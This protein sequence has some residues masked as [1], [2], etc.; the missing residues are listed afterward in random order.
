LYPLS[1]KNPKEKKS[2][3]HDAG[4]LLELTT[5]RQNQTPTREGLVPKMATGKE[6]TMEN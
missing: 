1:S 4:E 6:I 5:L 2:I 3:H